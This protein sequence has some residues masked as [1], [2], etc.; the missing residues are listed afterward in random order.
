MIERGELP[1]VD[2]LSFTRAQSAWVDFE[3]GTQLIFHGVYAALGMTGL[4]VLKQLLMAAAAAVLWKTAGLYAITTQGRCAALVLFSAGLLAHAD[5]RPDLI[6]T[7]LFSVLLYALERHRLGGRRLDLKHHAGFFA[8]F[9]VWSNL[10]AGFGAGLALVAFYAA[11]GFSRD[12]ILAAVFCAAGSLM[13]PYGWQPY[14]VMAGHWSQRAELARSI[15]EWQPITQSRPFHW[16]FWPVLAAVVALVWSRRR[17]AGFPR[18]LAAAVLFFAY[19]GFAHARLA[20]YFNSAAVPLILALSRGTDWLRPA[21]ARAAALLAGLVCAAYLAW[22]LSFPQWGK[23]FDSRFVPV[24][25]AEFIAGEQEVFQ[26]LRLYNPWEWGGYLGWR[27]H[28]WHK[29]FGDGRYLF[30]GLLAEVSA[31]V[32]SP[33]TCGAFLNKYRVDAALMRNSDSLIAENT[34]ERLLRPW[35]VSY[36]PKEIW[37]LVYWDPQAMIFVRRDRVPSRWLKNH[38]Y[39]HVLPGDEPTLESALAREGSVKDEAEA[40]ISRHRLERLLY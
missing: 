30:H 34:E 33:E 28:P 12:M 11:A 24:H 35:Y 10:H 17:Q 6:S 13:N 36:M 18:G 8:L 22:A 26:G 29:V 2:F 9:A 23:I 37:A 4:W 19:Q 15:Q 21:V 5:I 31:A 3:W 32:S 7:L 20:A 27:L 39:R 1:R 25:A 14:A 38:E 16:P 40:E